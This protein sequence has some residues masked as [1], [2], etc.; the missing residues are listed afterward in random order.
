MTVLRG[1]KHDYLGMTLDFSKSGAF[2]VDVEEYL[3][4][5]IKDLPEPPNSCFLFDQKS[6]GTSMK[7]ITRN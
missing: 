5:I 3:T 1:K 2:I 6:P 7:M 4:E